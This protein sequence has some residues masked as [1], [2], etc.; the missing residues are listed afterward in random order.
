MVDGEKNIG[1]ITNVH[2]VLR[3]LMKMWCKSYFRG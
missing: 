2:N 1:E 3:F